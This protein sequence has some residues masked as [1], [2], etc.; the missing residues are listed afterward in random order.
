MRF[1]FQ[2]A[3][4]KIQ[5]LCIERMEAE[6]DD[7]L[8]RNDRLVANASIIEDLKNSMR[9]KLQ[10]TNSQRNG[11]IIWLKHLE[12]EEIQQSIKIQILATSDDIS[13]RQKQAAKRLDHEIDNRIN[14]DASLKCQFTN[15]GLSVDEL[16][17]L[18]II[19]DDPTTFR[20]RLVQ[21][22]SEISW[23]PLDLSKMTYAVS[24]F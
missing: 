20:S 9:V 23:H 8:N 14:K 17:Y 18:E 16:Q 11:Y 21:S 22:M 1:D 19:L 13:T 7:R 6:S 12:L 5:A 24:C 15:A 10:K 2:K 4:E 3:E